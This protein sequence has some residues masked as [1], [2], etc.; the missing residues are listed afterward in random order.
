MWRSQWKKFLR[1]WKVMTWC[2]SEADWSLCL[3]TDLNLSATCG[4]PPRASEARDW[5]NFYNSARMHLRHQNTRQWAGAKIKSKYRLARIFI[6]GGDDFVIKAFPPS[7]PARFSFFSIGAIKFD[8]ESEVRTKI[9]DDKPDLH[10]GNKGSITNTIHHCYY[11]GNMHHRDSY[12][13]MCLFLKAAGNRHIFIHV[14]VV[15]W[16]NIKITFYSKMHCL[17]SAV[18]ECWRNENIKTQLEVVTELSADS[19]MKLLVW[20]RAVIRIYSTLGLR[21]PPPLP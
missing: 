7:L 11:K 21:Q 15:W 19:L 13:S 5:G 17:I 3:W 20:T 10:K 18:K 16:E 9:P 14:I 12:R 4:T 2:K 1:L 6:H 8:W